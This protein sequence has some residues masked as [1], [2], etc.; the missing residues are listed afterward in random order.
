VLITER[1]KIVSE[2]SWQ[3]EMFLKRTKKR[4]NNGF[5][6]DIVKATKA[7]ERLFLLV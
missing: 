1:S 2:V 4:R 5:L 3:K 6:L 7:K